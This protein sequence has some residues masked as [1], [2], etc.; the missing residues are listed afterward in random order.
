[1]ESPSVTQAGGQ[2]HDIS[3]LQP[4]PARFK[5]FSCLSLRRWGFTM[6]ARLVSNSR[7]HVIRPSRPSKVLELQPVPSEQLL[8][9][10]AAR[11]RGKSQCLQSQNDGS[12]QEDRAGHGSLDL[13]TN[14]RMHVVRE[15]EQTL[16]LVDM[17]SQLECQNTLLK[18]LAN[19]EQLEKFQSGLSPKKQV[20]KSQVPEALGDSAVQCLE[21]FLHSKSRVNRQPAEWEK[22]FTIYASNK[23]LISTVYKEL[24]QISKKKN[25]IKNSAKDMNRQF[26]KEDIHMANKHM[27]KCSIT[28]MTREKQVKGNDCE[29]RYLIRECGEYSK[30]EVT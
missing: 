12:R 3:S 10:E 22:T 15:E 21:G 4:P 11:I 7:P 8:Q 23:E 14:H 2:W 19:P 27:K 29:S 6:L 24:K 1:M 16:E 26:S 25:P 5:R 18:T 28:L 17:N 9:P 20:P 30:R 13:M